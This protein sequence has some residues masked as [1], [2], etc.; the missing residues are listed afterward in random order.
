[1]NF[2]LTPKETEEVLRLLRQNTPVPPLRISQ[3]K[4]PSPPNQITVNR[5]ERCDREQPSPCLR[6]LTKAGK[7]SELKRSE[8]SFDVLP[9]AS[10]DSVLRA[11]KMKKTLGCNKEASASQGVEQSFT[12]V[13]VATKADENAYR[14][15]SNESCDTNFKNPSKC[16]CDRKLETIKVETR[17]ANTSDDAVADDDSINDSDEDVLDGLA[18]SEIDNINKGTQQQQQARSSSCVEART[19]TQKTSYFTASSQPAAGAKDILRQISHAL[20]KSPLTSVLTSIQSDAG[21]HSGDSREKAKRVLT[22]STDEKE[23]SPRCSQSGRKKS[24]EAAG[25]SREEAREDFVKS[26]SLLKQHLMRKPFLAHEREPIDG[27]VRVRADR[28][29][30]RLTSD[31]AAG[32]CEAVVNGYNKRP[33]LLSDEPFANEEDKEVEDLCKAKGVPIPST[34]EKVKFRRSLDSAA[35]LVFHNKTGLPLT[36]SP[37]PLR[38]GT[39]FDFDS[40]LNCIAAIRR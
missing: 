37:A 14:T 20:G 2:D 39:S 19:I 13:T 38:K 4:G 16:K 32:D 18:Q 24:A 33:L 6:L 7:A 17:L 31:P 27:K 29:N 11:G 10:K 12:A 15:S 21:E 1:M 22:F 36:S 26:V 28:E 9:S 30:G 40:T 34:S 35:T 23:D 5:M 3:H 25:P 8:A